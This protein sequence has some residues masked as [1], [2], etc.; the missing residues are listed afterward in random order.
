VAKADLIGRTMAEVFPGIEATPMYTALRRTMVLRT[1]TRFEN[2]FIYPDGQEGWFDLRL[3]PVP[4]GVLILSLDITE[5]KLAE[6]AL[7]RS[8]S[9]Y[10]E[11]FD[12]A[13]VGMFRLAG[14]GQRVLDANPKLGEILGVPVDSLLHSH[15]GIRW[16]EPHRFEEFLSQLRERLAIDHAEL[17]VFTAAGERRSCLVS[18]AVLPNGSG[19]EGTL[20]DI[21][22]RIADE[23]RHLKLLAAIHQAAEAVVVTDT[24]GLISYVNPAFERITGYRSDEVV[25][26]N[27]RILKSG[28]QDSSYYRELWLA[29]EREGL[30][31][32]RMVNRRK[33][34]TFYTQEST[35]S[36]VSDGN[37]EPVGYVAV[38]RDISG[39]LELEAQLAH[40]QR[41]ETIG[42]LTG[43]IAHD[44][45]NLLSV[46]LGSTE[47]VL[48]EMPEYDGRRADLEEIQAAGE[49]A[50]ALTRQLLAFG[51]RQPL[52]REVIDFADV[53]R[54]IEPM[55]R[56]LVPS[57]IVVSV[58]ATA[59]CCAVRADPAQLDQLIMNL[60]VNARDAMPSGGRLTVNVSITEL[61]EA[62]FGERATVKPG[63]Y[64]RLTVS[65][66]GVGMDEATRARA[67]EPFFTTKEV[68]K[69]T[70]L[71]L[72]MVYGIVHQCGGH[73]WLYSEPGAGTTLKSYLPCVSSDAPSEEMLPERTEHVGAGE[74][75]LVVE[76]EP[77]VLAITRRVLLDAGY[78]VLTAASVHDARQIFARFS[79]EI[80]LV[81][82]DVVMPE[83]GGLVLADHLRE[84][85][86]ELPIL[87][88]SGYAD[89]AVLHRGLTANAYPILGKP[90][91]AAELRQ[92]VREMLPGA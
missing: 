75:L 55:V 33:D 49:R 72:A 57:D 35:I 73:I 42:R 46:I 77:A 10:R 62:S 43:G 88:M 52:T 48:A 30:W 64:V 56:R 18:A 15:D 85:K 13:Q 4:E 1:A 26:H 69:G 28:Q 68:G 25:G 44:F 9:K 78:R 89:D 12:H 6:A 91:S 79:D 11:L 51:R 83:G 67:F 7:R 63:R 65:D 45:N 17:D 27:P 34:G 84:T 66:T 39:E 90:F 20:R 32:G 58:H 61:D 54:K 37:G 82:S 38:N 74:M 81:L 60:V 5:Q 76:D 50:A 92:R 70:G 47:F 8:E 2:H 80:G 40:A 23:R 41:M 21:S 14:D 29:L 3:M 53:V 24:A 22:Q 71:G 59:D 31:R 19:I 16:A 36:R 86:P 87:L